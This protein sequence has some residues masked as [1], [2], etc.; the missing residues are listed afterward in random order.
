MKHL[1]LVFACATLLNI[2]A[3]DFF[4]AQVLVK[5]FDEL[6]ITN[7]EVQ[8]TDT[9][10]VVL[11]K[12]ITDQEGQFEISMKPGKYRVKLYINGELKKDRSINLPVLTGQKIYNHVRIFVL[13]EDRKQFVLEDLFFETNSAILA[14]S[15]FVIL[16]KLIEYLEY[17][18]ENKFEISGY[19]DNV[20]SDKSN[21]VLSENRA[22]AVVNYLVEH[23]IAPERLVAKGYGE[24]NPI[25]DNSTEEGRAQNR[26]TEIKKI[27]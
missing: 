18:E 17:E 8:L 21:Q 5:N 14:E 6:K 9:N 3:Q 16:D 7:A 4:H 24:L 23:G 10:G 19:T 25:A 11:H 2:Q 26:R 12:G 13:Y 27:D 20:G 15:S 1:L 22:I